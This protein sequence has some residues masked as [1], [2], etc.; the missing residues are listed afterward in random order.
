M[1]RLDPKT[2]KITDGNVLANAVNFID[3][4]MEGFSNATKM[5]DQCFVAAMQSGATISHEQHHIRLGNSR[6]RLL[7]H[8][9]VDTVLLAA[10]SS[11][12]ND[13]KRPVLDSALSVLSISSQAG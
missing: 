8:R 11:G 7:G 4:Q 10:N 2:I 6:H 5:T 13:D 1:D 12:I 3:H 9:G